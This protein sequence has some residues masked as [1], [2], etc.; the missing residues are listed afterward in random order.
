MSIDAMKHALAV[1]NTGGNE[2]L[3]E[4]YGQ[5]VSEA[6][7]ALRTAINHAERPQTHSE[8]CWRWHHQCAIGKIERM[9]IAIE[10]LARIG[11]NAV[12]QIIKLEKTK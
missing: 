4:D 12:D 3:P 5:M 10:G 6:I 8:E 9:Q 1:L 2:V 11:G 7:T